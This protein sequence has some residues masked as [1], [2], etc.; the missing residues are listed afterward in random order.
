MEKVTGWGIPQTARIITS[1]GD[2]YAEENI[3]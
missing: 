3:I 1:K 2:W